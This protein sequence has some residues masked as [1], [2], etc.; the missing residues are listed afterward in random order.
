MLV[1]HVGLLVAQRKHVAGTAAA[2]W[3]EV[4]NHFTVQKYQDIVVR[5]LGQCATDLHEKVGG[6]RPR[7]AM[8][9]GLK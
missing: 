1:Q 5:C 7:L 6:V 4:D 8:Q 2:Q 9:I 3:T